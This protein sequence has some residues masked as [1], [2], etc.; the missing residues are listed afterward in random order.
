[1]LRSLPTAIDDALDTLYKPNAAF[2]QFPASAS[3][4]F[5][6][7]FLYLLPL[8]VL[9]FLAFLVFSFLFFPFSFF[10]FSVFSFFSFSL[11]SLLFYTSFF[12][13]TSVCRSYA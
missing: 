8:L 4:T 13:L 6:S 9:S 5:F 2:R 11:S 12:Q 1:M 7:L 10:H 3:I